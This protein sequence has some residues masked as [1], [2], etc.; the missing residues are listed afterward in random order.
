M[1][2]V[3][4]RCRRPVRVTNRFSGY[5]AGSA[6]PATTAMKRPSPGF[7]PC[8]CPRALNGRDRIS[9]SVLRSRLRTAM[10]EPPQRTRRS[11]KRFGSC[12]TRGTEIGSAGASRMALG[13]FCEAH[14]VSSRI[15]MGK[16][17]PSCCPHQREEDRGLC[18]EGALWPAHSCICCPLRNMR[19]QATRDAALHRI[20]QLAA[21]G[22]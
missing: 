4:S 13:I 16:S 18:G 14:P 6:K 3:C 17:V 22:C 7:F 8:G 19:L 20:G 1:G 15:R 2:R 9:I 12:C 10:I 5:S 11:R 21:R